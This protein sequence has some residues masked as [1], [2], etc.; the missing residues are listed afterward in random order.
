VTSYN[1]SFINRDL[2]WMEFNRR[3]LHQAER[4]DIPLL[5][6]L[7]FLGIT[8]SNLD[9]FIMVRL[10]SILKKIERSSNSTEISG[11]K[12]KEEYKKLLKEI[13]KFKENQEECYEKIEKKLN[14]NNIVISKYKHLTKK[15]KRQLTKLFFKNIYPQLKPITLNKTASLSL[16]KSK[17]LCIIVK[18]K[19]GKDVII[20]ISKDLQ[21]LYEINSEYTNERKFISLEEI[22]YH[23]LNEMFINKKI[24]YYGTMRVIREADI[25]IDQNEKVYLVDR[26]KHVL[27][28]RETSGIIF[29]EVNDDIPK[30]FLKHLIKIFNVNKKRIYKSK[31]FL[32]YSFFIRKPIQDVSHEYS[33]FEPQHS[34]EL[35]EQCDMFEAIKENDILLHHPYESFEPVIRFLEQAAEDD[36]VLSIRQTLYRVSSKDSPIVDALCK[37]AQKGKEVKVLLEIKARFDEAQNLSLIKKLKSAGCKVTY[38]IEKLKVHSKITLIDRKS[39][40]DEI[41]YYCHIGTGNYNERTAELYTDISYFTSNVKIAKD[42]L[43]IFNVMFNPSHI[44]IDTSMVAYSPINVRSIFYKLVD[45]EI[46][47]A[48]NGKEAAIVLKL[49]SLSDAGV[50]QKLYDASERGVKVNVFSR[51]ICSM[52]P[53]NENI[54]I[55]SLVGRYLEHDRIYYFHNNGDSKVYISSADL[56]T[57]NLDKRIEVMVPIM[58]NEAKQK[59]FNILKTCYSD[60][61]NAWVMNKEGKYDLLSKRV[62]F[63]AH[64]FLMQQVLDKLILSKHFEE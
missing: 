53:I 2:S 32:D 13:M 26:M 7:K 42:I 6:R 12:P 18:I 3:V 36:K 52:K 39:K 63:D 64:D 27:R 50:I 10:H 37:A 30:K 56:L 57:R 22:I 14:K 41:K 46:D 61:F 54:S 1:D 29:M 31:N 58:D 4:K 16:I 51:G 24:S 11:L 25:E 38:G 60:S 47:N 28:E 44:G 8:T 21:R 33:Q 20:P 48:D 23:H 17:Q 55:R 62:D 43:I 19:N 34:K 9:E 45:R 15:E 59:L 40:D 49:N 35:S 5:E